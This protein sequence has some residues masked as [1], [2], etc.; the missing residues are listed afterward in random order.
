MDHDWFE[1]SDRLQFKIEIN[2]IF[3]NKGRNYF[4]IQIFIALRLK[5]NDYVKHLQQ[6]QWIQKI[7][8]YLS[9]R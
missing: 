9:N 2:K 7:F 3:F 6:Q 4:A 5:I 8:G 1:I